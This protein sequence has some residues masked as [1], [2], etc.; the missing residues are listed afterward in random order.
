MRALD[1]LGWAAGFCFR[2]YGLR[3]GVRT[4]CPAF[5]EEALGCLP[6]GAQLDAGPVVDH[7][8]SAVVGDAPGRRGV[9]R[10]HLLYAD[11]LR[12]TRT[13]YREE[14]VGDLERHIEQMLLVASPRR[15]FVHSGAVGWRGV[16]LL[17]PG[18][19][20]SGKSTLVAELVRLGASYFSDEYAVVD[21][22]GR[23]HPYPRPLKLRS[24]SGEGSVRVQE[25]RGR[26]GMRPLPIGLIAFVPFRKG[27]RWAPRRL[28]PGSA[29]L[30]L[31]RNTPCTRLQPGKALSLVRAAASRARAIEGPRGE[32]TE[33]A[34]HLIDALEAVSCE[35]RLGRSSDG[36]STEG[37]S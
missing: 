7:L 12:V 16:G 28:S 36:G 27:A 2:A 37:A 13:P 32:A 21:L 29:A 18:A 20:H 35:L 17:V 6:A 22:R 26:T 5:L 24:Q 14:F 9:R 30:G 19:S 34:A 1:R 4:N 23:V 11:A 15:L 31:L 8:F 33:V 25:L 3:V 10:L